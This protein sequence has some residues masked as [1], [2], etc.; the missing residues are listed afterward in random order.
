MRSIFIFMDYQINHEKLSERV[1]QVLRKVL[2]TSGLYLFLIFIIIGLLYLIA[3]SSL[4]GSLEQLTLISNNQEALENLIISKTSEISTLNVFFTVIMHFFLIG[5]F[6]MIEKSNH[7]PIV[8][9]GS[10]FK[11]VFSKKG[12]ISLNIII[13]TQLLSSGLSYL[14]NTLGFP[15]VGFA[16]SILIQFLT[17]FAI[18]AVFIQKT[19]VTKSLLTSINIVNNKPGT[20]FSF[21]IITY[22][23]SLSGILFFGV[24]LLF[25]LPLNY[26]VS[27]VLFE[28]I[29]QQI[30]N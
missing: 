25:T 1:F 29:H 16:L 12:L 3:F 14:L 10:A 17:F 24:G 30:K 11:A 19:C 15:M 13:I 6:G 21:V 8:S 23:L 5:V 4:I 20:I 9:L 7:S 2:V 28:H 27:Y 26:I 22:L 18:P